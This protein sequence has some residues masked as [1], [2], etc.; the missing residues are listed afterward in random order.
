MSSKYIA[1]GVSLLIKAKST[2]VPGLTRAQ[3]RAM[4]ALGLSLTTSKY[5]SLTSQSGV[6]GSYSDYKVINDANSAALKTCANNDNLCTTVAK[7]G[8]VWYYITTTGN[9]K[10]LVNPNLFSNVSG[11]FFILITTGAGNY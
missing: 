8:A 4:D 1:D 9:S 5:F 3:D 6:P 7:I 10:V 11:V 2:S